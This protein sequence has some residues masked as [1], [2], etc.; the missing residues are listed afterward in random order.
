MRIETA[1]YS[2]TLSVEELERLVGNRAQVMKVISGQIERIEHQAPPKLLST[3]IARPRVNT[4]QPCP[5][6]GLL[7]ES[8]G[9]GVHFARRHKTRYADYLKKHNGD[10][11]VEQAAPL[12][13]G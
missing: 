8:R 13:E 12:L 10:A 6:C 1:N 9:L 11:H 4:K 7:M 5:K 3:T 2:V